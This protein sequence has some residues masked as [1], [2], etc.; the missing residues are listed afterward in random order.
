[1]SG[2]SEHKLPTSNNNSKRIEL[3]KESSL[4]KNNLTAAHTVIAL[5]QNTKNSIC[6]TG[7]GITSYS[8]KTHLIFSK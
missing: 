6:T 1:M 5:I 3:V 8:S 7:Y 2:N 4:W